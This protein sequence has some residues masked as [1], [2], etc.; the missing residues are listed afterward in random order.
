[1]KKETILKGK[2]C[3]IREYKLSDVSEIARLANNKKIHKNLF[4]DFP[5]PYKESDALS[6]IK[7][8]I[9]ET[10]K[11]KYPLSMVITYEDRVAGGIGVGE[12]KGGKMGFGYWLGEEFWG[13]GIATDAVKVFTEYVFK[14]FKPFKVHANVFVWNKGSQRVLEKNGFNLDGVFKKDYIKSGK[15]IDQCYYSKLNPKKK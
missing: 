13:K 5:N 15:I 3:I 6:W 14:I 4:E 12:L 11:N 8:V 7:F 1:M 2:I 9:K 10:K